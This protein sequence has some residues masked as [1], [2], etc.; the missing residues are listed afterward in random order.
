MN[1]YIH[2]RSGEVIEII[3][4]DAEMSRVVTVTAT[5]AKIRSRLMKTTSLK[6]TFHNT[7]GT[8]WKAAYVRLDVLPGNHPLAPK[9]EGIATA[10]REEPKRLS[11]RLPNLEAMSDQELTAYAN[12]KKAEAEVMKNLFEAAKK[13][14]RRRYTTSGARLSGNVYVEISEN[15][16]FNPDLAQQ[17][18]T[19]EEYAKILVPVPNSD[20]ARELLADDEARYNKLCKT[21]DNKVE[22]RSAR[23]VDYLNIPTAEKKAD[24]ITEEAIAFGL[25]PSELV[26]SPF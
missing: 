6:R 13:E 4:T 17:H 7:K 24:P 2:T 9:P 5:G 19:P 10:D 11:H 16:R 12:T 1:Q 15:R 21:F 22:I 23:P 20:L 26:D 8:P 18:L 25:Y 14:V 3:G